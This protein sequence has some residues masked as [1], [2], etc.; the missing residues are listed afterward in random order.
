MTHTRKAVYD[1]GRAAVLVRAAGGMYRKR[2]EIKNAYKVGGISMRELAKRHDVSLG[3]VQSCL[4]AA[5]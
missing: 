5:A 1:P 4:R 3:T 2:Q